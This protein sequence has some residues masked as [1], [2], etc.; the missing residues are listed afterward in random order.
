[1]RTKIIFLSIITA[2]ALITI[3][4]D[5]SSSEETTRRFA[6]V[7]GAND[8][9]ISRTRLQYAVSDADA[10]MKVLRKMG[11]VLPENSLL[12]IEPDRETY[13]SGMKNIREK[14]IKGRAVSRRTE[15]IFYYSGHSDE[16]AILL[17]KEKISY[18]EIKNYITGMPA[19]VHIAILDSCSSGAFSRIKG[20]TKRTPFLS[21]TAYSMKGFAFMTSSSMDEASQESDKIN[22]SFFTHYLLS[23]LRGAAD[24]NQDSRVTLNEA[25]Q[26]AYNE[27]LAGT[28]KSLSGPQHPNYNI[29]MSG[30]GDVIMTDI[31]KSSAIM[32]LSEEISGKL[33]IRDNNNNL[34]CELRKTA[35]KK[36]QF[37]LEEGRYFI[38]EIEDNKVSEAEIN[39]VSGKDILLSQNNFTQ[40]EKEY[41]IN[42]GDQNEN[43]EDIDSD[44]TLQKSFTVSA[45]GMLNINTDRGS[46][47]VKGKSGNTI[48]IRVSNKTKDFVVKFDKRGK[49]LFVNGNFQGGPFS[50]L[51]NKFMW[52]LTDLHFEITV[53]YNYNTD[54]KTFGGKIEVSGIEGEVKTKTSGGGLRFNDISGPV[55]GKTAGGSIEVKKCTGR[56]DIETL[57]GTIQIDR[58][59]GDIKSH[60]T[61]GSINIKSVN[62]NITADT[63]G[64][65][66]NVQEVK[67]N[68]NVR[69]SGG[70][71]DVLELNGSI[72]AETFGGSINAQLLNQPDKNCSLSTTGG[73]VI[74][75]LVKN[76]AVDIDAETSGG[77]VVSD[78]PVTAQINGEIKNSVLKG[79]INGGGPLMYL[80]TT[81][82]NIHI[83]K[84]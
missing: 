24:M 4:G 36:I 83:E 8:G 49:D 10:M 50:R 45:G 16:E 2:A 35:G 73:S 3:S 21:D 28:E 29:Q 38:T 53:P 9:G 7:A 48:K 84:R 81:G 1:M 19:D 82:G 61:G 60:T 31:R 70:T 51:W 46:I 59:D 14:I 69:T 33:Y 76:T 54:I 79:K 17:G 52:H 65:R 62:G 56:I 55:T 42:R 6:L 18:K 68:I 25:Y 5:L 23:G 39:L 78:F 26:F 34:I 12:L 57:G 72:D 77:R 66:I 32:T 30:T 44:D 47:D 13:L 15:L 63:F 71:I 41:T 27:T 80:R 75:Y 74:I 64:G 43:S 67:G 20:G 40:K 58:A 37:G 11:G 22:G